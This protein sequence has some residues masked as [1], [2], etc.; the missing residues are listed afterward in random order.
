[1]RAL[2]IGLI[3]IST[4]LCAQTPGNSAQTIPN[5][6][7]SANEATESASQPVSDIILSAELT[8]GIDARKAQVGDTVFAKCTQDLDENGEIG[9]PRNAKLVGHVVSVQ[10]KGRG[11]PESVLGI[12][13]DRAILRD[14]REIPLTA[15]IQALAPPPIMASEVGDSDFDIRNVSPVKPRTSGIMPGAAKT[16][17]P[18]SSL[19]ITAPTLPADASGVVGLKGVQLETVPFAAANTSVIHSSSQNVRLESGTRLILRVSFP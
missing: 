19:R 8:R 13:F 1:M 12:V 17:T 18:E 14:G 11:K 2:L 6:V 4:T 5:P 9:I 3:A 10:T 15:A 7:A 16:V